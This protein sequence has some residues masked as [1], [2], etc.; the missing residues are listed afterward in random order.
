MPLRNTILILNGPKGSGKDVIAKKIY[1]RTSALVHEFKAP[2]HKIAMGM[3]GLEPRQYYSIY[4]DR[5]RKETPQ[6]EFLGLS[7]RE[8]LIWISEEVCKP[9]FGNNFFGVQA[10]K[11]I[12][13][14]RGAVFS[15]GGFI[16]EV[17]ELRNQFPD[18]NIV[19]VRL[20]REG[21]TFE[22]DSRNYITPQEAKDAGVKLV[23]VKNNS[24]IE[25]A[26]DKVLNKVL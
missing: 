5:N 1:Q 13:I 23:K 8:M 15:D 19:V 24:T 2:L 20:I 7:P 22:G 3:T 6:P 26:A 25:A 11:A 18:A 14:N 17:K 9:K 10:A 4:N 12:D 16:D 21:H